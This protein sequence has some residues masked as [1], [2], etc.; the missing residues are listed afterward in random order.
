[1]FLA[2]DFVDTTS[3]S[4]RALARRWVRWQA[5]VH[6]DVLDPQ[7]I[8][9]PIVVVS[10]HQDDEVLGCGGTV[11]LLRDLGRRVLFVFLMDGSRSHKPLID[12]D[13]L[14]RIR[15]A[16]A[17][18]AA[19]ELGLAADD[20]VFLDLPDGK[21]FKCID[22][23]VVRLSSVF[24]EVEP[25]EVFVTSPL[26]TPSDHAGASAVVRGALAAH[27]APVWL[28][29]FPV[30]GLY[31]WPNV[32][33]PLTKRSVRRPLK[34]RRELEK[35]FDETMRMR[36]GVR[37][38]RAFPTCVDVTSVIDVKRRALAAHAS[39]TTRFRPDPRWATLGDVANGAFVEAFFDGRERF[40]RY[41]FHPPRAASLRGAAS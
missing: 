6:E 17:L 4:A 41:L 31:H 21:L 16:E 37:L 26:E 38:Y 27:P 35:V 36:F 12:P 15:R 25:A 8:G 11:R 2:G 23:G 1:V 18:T 28:N 32:P 10:P 19:G 5:G 30:W 24:A 34:P 39:Q 14:R 3:W 33:L 29:E 22:E 9:E 40:R 13:E 7:E 20:V